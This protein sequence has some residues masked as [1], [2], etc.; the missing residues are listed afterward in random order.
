MTA[1]FVKADDIPF[2]VFVRIVFDPELTIPVAECIMY[3][4]IVGL[5]A[6][7]ELLILRRGTAF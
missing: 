5:P 2:S 6:I 3:K 1:D 4:E 7:S